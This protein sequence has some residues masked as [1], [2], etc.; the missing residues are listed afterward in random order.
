MQSG[1]V[2]ILL[3]VLAVAGVSAVG[4][5]SMAVSEVPPGA[6]DVQEAGT[7]AVPAAASDPREEPA[8]LET[9]DLAESG[10]GKTQR[11][12]TAR[13]RIPADRE[14]RKESSLDE[15]YDPFL[16]ERFDEMATARP[17]PGSP[18]EIFPEGVDPQE[19]TK[20]RDLEKITAQSK[21]MRARLTKKINT[22]GSRMRLDERTKEDL[23]ETH[24]E[25]L[26]RMSEIRGEFAGVE[27][28]DS[29]RKYMKDQIRAAYADTTQ[30]IRGFLGDKEFKQFRRESRYYDN[31]TARIA[32]DLRE[33]KKQN[34]ELQKKI[35]RQGKRKQKPGPNRRKPGRN[36]RPSQGR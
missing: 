36:R 8:G 16:G 18:R 3:V 6:A 33:I 14:S 25:G 30:N 17:K 27:M 4:I 11:L 22:V 31:P 1:F 28:T 2:R 15:S 10:P 24:L 20:K 29:D 19:I 12:Q 34:R 35:N 9:G 26:E 32:D 23:L 5:Y 7:P 13:K 21:K